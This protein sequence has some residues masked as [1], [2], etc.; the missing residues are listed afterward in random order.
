[1]NDW[2]RNGL[3]VRL[4][5]SRPRVWGLRFLGRLVIHRPQILLRLFQ[6]IQGFWR[7]RQ[8]YSR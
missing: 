2:Q 7:R 8:D 5:P 1:L 6:R 3:V 4:P